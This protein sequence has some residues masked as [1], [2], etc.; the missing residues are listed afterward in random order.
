MQTK[1]LGKLPDSPGVY[2]FLNKSGKIL[3]IGKATSL[4]NRVRSYF[5]SDILEKRSPLIAKMV[6]EARRV[7]FQKTNSVLEALIL[8]AN[9]V[10]KHLPPYNTA[11]KDQKS[12]NYIV[13]TKE[14][15]PRVLVMREREIASP[16]SPLPLKRVRGKETRT[17][18]T[19]KYGPFT[20]GGELKEALKIIR[21]IFPFRDKCK[22][23]Q[24]R[25]CFNYQI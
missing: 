13:I 7:K 16:P 11:E 14:E 18:I 21:K 9:L 25:A 6:K 15:F 23:N 8:E 17:I 22:L 2:Y 3:Y 10:K 4:K 20:N 24:E 12:W 5:A 1:L 19:Y